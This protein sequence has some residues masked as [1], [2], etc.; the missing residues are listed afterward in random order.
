MLLDK[1]NSAV[2]MYVFPAS[3]LCMQTV[4]QCNYTSLVTYVGTT[5]LERQLVEAANTGRFCDALSQ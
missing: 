5:E 2:A 3:M 1:P 4:Q